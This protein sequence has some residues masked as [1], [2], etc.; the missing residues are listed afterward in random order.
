M[1][2]TTIQVTPDVKARLE[3]LKRYAKESY[4]DVIIRLLDLAL[5]TEPLSDEA[6]RGIE[7]A[8]EDIKAGRV[9]PEEEIAR[10]FCV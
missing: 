4:N 3:G 6:I 5:D 8:L 10:E 1:A 2:V 9:Y 7:E